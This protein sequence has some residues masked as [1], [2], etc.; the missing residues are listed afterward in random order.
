MTTYMVYAVNNAV[1]G[2][3]YIGCTN[4]KIENR[5]NK[6]YRDAA[7]KSTN[8][9]FHKALRKY[10]KDNFY[11]TI[12]GYYNSRSAM[13]QAEVEWIA[14]FDSYYSDQGYNDTPGGDGGPTNQGKK[15]DDE[16]KKNLSAGQRGRKR[17]NSENL[18]KANKNNLPTNRKLTFDQAEEIRIKYKN[19]VK[20]CDLAKIYN[21]A[22][23]SL[24]N[25][26]ELKTY[27]ERDGKFE[28]QFI[29]KSEDRAIYQ[30]YIISNIITGNVYFG[31]S[32]I[33][34]NRVLNKHINAALFRATN[35]K[36]HKDINIYGEDKFYITCLEIHNSKIEMQD[37]HKEWIKFLRDYSDRFV[38]DISD[39][40]DS[41]TGK[42][43]SKQQKLASTNNKR[44]ISNRITFDQAND[45]RVLYQDGITQKDLANKYNTSVKTI[46]QIIK[47]EII[48]KDIK[49]G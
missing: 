12:I 37:G 21:M 27:K 26:I 24:R 19:G 25:I 6:H 43:L 48:T 36:L 11:L 20:Y 14:F 32:Q 49:H 40:S 15:F 38:V 7:N 44:S 4:Q 29:E 2:K 16:W 10:G 3:L 47:N 33:I 17:K 5:L 22:E 41:L 23:S 42:P 28:A 31:S 35:S 34:L 30:N 9:S 8:S 13:L 18:S 46:R 1:N 45:I 39:T